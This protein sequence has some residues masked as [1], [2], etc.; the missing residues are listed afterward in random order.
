[1][2][3]VKGLA[4]SPVPVLVE[5]LP[6]VRRVDDRRAGPE[7]LRAKRRGEPRELVVRLADRAVVVEEEGLA[8]VRLLPRRSAG[9]ERPVCRLEVEDQVRVEDVDVEEEVPG[10]LAFHEADRGVDD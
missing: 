3:L 7:V 1:M 4:V 5:L 6:V 10:R 8:L 9:E 2:L